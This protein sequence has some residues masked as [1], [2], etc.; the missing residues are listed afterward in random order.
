MT[1]ILGHHSFRHARLLLLA[2]LC[3]AGLQV[4]EA[5]HQHGTDDGPVHCLLCKSSADVPLPAV[6]PV[7]AAVR[8]GQSWAR[9]MPRPAAREVFLPFNPRGPPAIS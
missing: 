9:V 3:V 5:A 6:E 7:V 1:R 4:Q 2:M 8:V